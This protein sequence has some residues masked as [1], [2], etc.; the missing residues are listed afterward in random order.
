M[1]IKKLIDN[2]Y[3]YETGGIL[4]Y[5]N[6]LDWMREIPDQSIDM[7]LADL[8]YEKTGIDWD[9]I[10]PFEP[11][12]TQYERIIKNNGAIVLTASQP[13]TTKLINSNYKLFKYSMVWIKDK[14]S[15]F[16]NANKMPMNYHE[17]I[18]LFYK[19]MPKFNK[20]FEE[21]EGTG[22]NRV[23]YDITNGFNE[24]DENNHKVGCKK[25]TK[26]YD[27]LRQIGSVIK[28]KIEIRKTGD[29]P[30]KKPIALFEHLI[31]TYT[32]ENDVVLDNVAGSCTT[33]IACKNLK[34]KWIC[35]EKEEKYCEI[36]KSR[37][38]NIIK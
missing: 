14:P 4:I 26:K 21:R 9:V 35:I 37:I 27:E 32:D 25:Q 19:N 22:K 20:S 13:F 10:I 18:L 7:I 23:K 12:W 31:K 17:D 28:I 30:T 5:G 38:L 34:R 33:A 16:A 29:H 11:L 1:T 3:Y 15:N 8:P 24:N 2:A 6:C 36:S